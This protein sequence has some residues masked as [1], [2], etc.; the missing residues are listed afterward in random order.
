MDEVSLNFTKNS[1]N[2]KILPDKRGARQSVQFN[3]TSHEFRRLGSG[4]GPQ[5]PAAGLLHRKPGSEKKK[6]KSVIQQS[7]E[8]FRQN[9]LINSQNSQSQQNSQFINQLSNIVKNIQNQEGAGYAINVNV[10]S[11]GRTDNA[12]IL[13]HNQS[14]DASLQTSP[15]AREQ[16]EQQEQERALQDQLEQERALQDQH[17]QH[18]QEP[19]PPHFFFPA[20]KDRIVQQSQPNLLSLKPGVPIPQLDCSS[21][22]NLSNC[23]NDE[24]LNNNRYVIQSP[25]NS[26]QS[27]VHLLQGQLPFTV[28]SAHSQFPNGSWLKKSG[29]AQVKQH[30]ASKSLAIDQLQKYHADAIEVLS[31]IENDQ[32]KD[33]AVIKFDKT[34]NQI[35]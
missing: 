10:A 3:L 19:Q 7:C 12:P 22:Y 20:S 25:Q 21:N 30:P 2:C 26:T 6:K 29:S 4:S 32:T 28:D 31:R 23:T 14:S 5:S 11:T 18:A 9:S 35:F 34:S 1:P 15:K 13:I 33:L 27:Q 17:A 24:A 8:F 16:Q